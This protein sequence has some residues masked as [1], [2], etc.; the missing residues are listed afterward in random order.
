MDVVLDVSL[1]GEGF[2]KKRLTMSEL[3]NKPLYCRMFTLQSTF[4]Q[5]PMTNF[6]A[7]SRLLLLVLASYTHPFITRSQAQEERT[8]G[9]DKNGAEI[10][11]E[12]PIL[13][14]MAKAGGVVSTTFN[15]SGA[16]VFFTVP[17]DV[18]QITIEARGGEGGDRSSSNFR[19]GKGAVIIGTVSVTPGQQL[20]ILVG[21]KPTTG[22][23]VNDAGGGSFVT[24]M[25]NNPLVI[26]GGGGGSGNTE[27]D[28]KHGQ[29]GNNGGNG[30]G[31]GGGTGGT[32]GNGGN[33]GNASTGGGGGL[34]GNGGGGGSLGG[35]SFTNGGG[36]GT[37]GSDFAGFGGGGF[38]SG[39]INGGGGG[40]YSGG[41][42][43]GGGGGGVG[44]GGGSFNGGT[45]QAST[46]GA[47]ANSGNG[48][49]IIT[50]IISDSPPCTPPTP[51]VATNNTPD[52]LAV[53]VSGG[54]QYERL[55][56]VDRIN[57]YEIRQTEQN[58]TGYFLITQRGPYSITVIGAD[59]CRATV[60]GTY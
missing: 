13:T 12:A 24:D 17:A 14:R 1:L 29:A 15:Y 28:Q 11:L 47:N 35:R 55:K 59:G 52:G 7:Y 51:F 48:L 43:G 39:F 8:P 50:C 41:G 38:G 5:T 40:G 45:N 6:Y 57:G 60:S 31:S 49:V 23:N 46:T 42:S 56:T 58:T 26:A 27:S 9:A 33:A 44:G 2:K 54:V 10:K 19:S 3:Q 30:A 25:S 18:N 36:G 22:F 20:K 21:Q 34:T 32:G 53:Q 37:D 4:P 16:S